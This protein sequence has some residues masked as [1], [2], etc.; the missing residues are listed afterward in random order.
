MSSA[1]HIIVTSDPAAPQ[2][3]TVRYG[4]HTWPCILGRSGIVAH[5]Q[6]G[7]GGTPVGTFPLRRVVY[8]ADRLPAPETILSVSAI[9][10]DDGWCDDP[11]DAAYNRPVK[12][13][14]AASTETMSRDDG[15]YDVVVIVGHNDDPVVPKAGS[16]IFMHIAEDNGAPTAGCVALAREDLL[17]LLRA[18]RPGAA[19]EIRS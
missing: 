1:P 16:A 18:L 13:P 6:E 2:R 19:L 4:A 17:S 12:L 10:G 11:A 7:D 8:R 3:G 5:K 14:Y 9:A 15:L